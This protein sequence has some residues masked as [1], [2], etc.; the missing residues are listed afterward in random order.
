MLVSWSPWGEHGVSSHSPM[1]LRVSP[2]LSI[3]PYP[4]LSL[5]GVGGMGLNQAKFRSYF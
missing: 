1:I 4:R 3:A 2:P 5:L